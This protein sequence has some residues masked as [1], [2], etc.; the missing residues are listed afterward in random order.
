MT[1]APAVSVVVVSRGRPEA[2]ARCLTGLT[3]LDYPAFEIV[4]IADGPGLNRIDMLPAVFGRI[5][6]GRFDSA[7]IS[8][9][10]NLGLAQAAGDI[11][12]FID[13]DA[14]PEPTWLRYLAEP[15]ADPRVASVGGT[16]IGRNGFT[17]QWGPRTVRATG[18][19][20]PLELH[21][22]GP[23][24]F[25]TQPGLGI[26]TEGTNMA[27]RRRILAA[28]GG[29]DPAFRFSHD[30]TD[31]NLRLTTE[32]HAAAIAPNA[33]VH[34]G[35]F[36]SE[37]RRSDR[38][39]LDLF[40]AGASLAVL[41]RKHAHAD[42]HGPAIA[43][44]RA[45]RRR[46]L[47]AHMVA[48]RLEPRDVGRLM[49]RFD[50]GVDDGRT[51][52]TGSLPPLPDPVAP[53]LRFPS[54]DVSRP[55]HRVVAGRVWRRRTVLAQAASLAR[56]GFVTTALILSPHARPHRLIYRMPGFWL[57]SGGLFGRSL[58]SDPVFLPWLFGRRVRREMR[59]V[60]EVRGKPAMDEGP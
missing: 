43:A 45:R 28:M 39:P 56:D 7:N 25:T 51:R 38:A 9:A 30:E 4:A 23:A 48:G 34:H 32:S 41:L 12:A 44:D 27:F 11:V 15:F 49:A 40:D 2:L 24:V 60:E 8:H 3:S 16:V 55:L 35:V 33:R 37:R 14:V 13:D 42:D 17:V 52:Q 5:K 6:R 57:Q 19:C 26:K 21:D 31:V 1:F 46:G 18:E 29:F 58:R 36:A 20:D 10:R 54:A 22:P 47:I 50:L 59:L 53:F